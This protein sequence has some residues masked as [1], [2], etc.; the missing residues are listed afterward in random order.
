MPKKGAKAKLKQKQKK[1]N[2]QSTKDIPSKSQ[3]GSSKNLH[4]AAEAELDAI[5]ALVTV[6]P[7]DH[8]KEF[9]R[10]VTL[11]NFSLAPIGGGAPL[12]RNANIKLTSGHRYG[13][14][15]Y[16]GAGKT[17]LLK[18]LASGQYKEIPKYLRV[19]HV[20][21][22]Q[23]GTEKTVLQTVL[24]ADQEREMLLQKQTQLTQA[25]N[26]F[27]EMPESEHT[28]ET[29]ALGIKY[30][31]QLNEVH[32]RL[33]F[34][35]SDTA[36]ARA[37]S[38]LQ[39]LQFS[40]RMKN[41][42]TSD[43][44]GGWRMRVSLAC[45]LF[46]APDILLLDEPTNHLDFPAVIW[47]T[48]YLA[49]EYPDDKTILIVSHD[50]RFLND[51]CTDI[52][53]LENCRMI[54]YKGNYEAFL[55]IRS[56]QRIHQRKQYERQ[57]KMISHNE[58]F[59]AR[60]KANKKWST[61]AQSRQK[62]LTRVS[63][64]EKVL[65]DLEF[66]FNF[67][68]P[69]PIKN[70]LICDLSEMSFG[71]YGEG[72]GTGK[73]AASTYILHQVALRV[74]M[75]EKIGILGANG[76][77]KSTLVKLIMQ[78]LKPVLGTSYLPNGVEVGYFAQHHL[79]ALDYNLT[80]IECLKKEFGSG[81]TQQQ[82][83]AQLGRF[84]IGDTYA[85]RRI[86]TLSGGQKSRVAFA[87]L[88]WY[89]PHLIIMDEPTNHLDMP[90]IDALAIALSDFEGTVMIVSHDQHF[91][92]TVCDEFWCVGNR[93]VKMFDDFQQCREFSKKC[94][95]PD[96]LPREF[97][98]V[99]VK[100]KVDVSKNYQWA[101]ATKDGAV[102]I[103]EDEKQ[104]EKKKKA[105]VVVNKAEVFKIDAERA[106]DKGLQK[107][108]TPNQTLRHLKGYNPE[109]GNV[110]IVT[111][112]GFIMFHDYF[113]DKSTKYVE[114]DHFEF[115]E[116]WQNIIQ[117]CIPSEHTRNQR[118]LLNIALKCFVIAK[119]D[120]ANNK[121]CNTTYSFGLML[122]ALVRRFQMIEAEIVKKYAQEHEQNDDALNEIEKDVIRQMNT[123]L[124][125][126]EDEDDDDDDNSDSD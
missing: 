4:S 75:G 65:G 124:V 34:I 85:R 1:Q 93:G 6:N 83:Y 39:G 125:M 8:I 13:L 29:D 70:D 107:G 61:Q 119:K 74:K 52:I 9:V 37:S 108:L 73:K 77:G 111:K 82:I 120:N 95:A 89:A 44:S 123:F 58:E 63:R 49:Y 92:E 30:V 50:R 117:Y 91:V 94:R 56:E 101:D 42:P 51:V 33:K 15:G 31:Q 27:N 90:T 41:M 97:A 69:N 40:N 36:E 64:I 5:S 115:F 67:P 102:T 109:D 71:Y 68:Q 17:T 14:I 106:I 110:M 10:D 47:L 48:E 98:T 46:V 103:D 28:A 62:L 114:L 12:I 88:T 11:H 26:K 60:F 76:A 121:R 25:M 22:E 105:P 104:K 3:N 79:E 81:V 66:R 84:N 122:E 7:D 55:K 96:V 19:L 2:K 126:A 99:S 20:H 100:K 116:P 45:A 18:A 80:P 59:I 24:A 57:Q 21:Q 78:E 87:I 35:E 32:D 43:L 23:M 118:E 113:D 16:N 72:T 53:H 86:G 38:V 54:Y 112:L